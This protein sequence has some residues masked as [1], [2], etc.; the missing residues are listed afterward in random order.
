MIDFAQPTDTQLENLAKACQPATFGLNQKDVLD[1]SYRKAFKMDAGR[2][3]THFSPVE[4]G[5]VDEMRQKL[6]KG[7]NS[8]SSIR[9]ELYKLNVYGT[10]YLEFATMI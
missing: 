10:S 3:A 2:F 9:V 8:E 7:S 1:E 6:L 5:L 4:L